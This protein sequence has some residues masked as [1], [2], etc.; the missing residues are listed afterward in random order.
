MQLP[1]E[2]LVETPLKNP[3][4]IEIPIESPL[5]NQ[6]LNRTPIGVPL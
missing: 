6:I 1:I 2:S 4:C 3:N 5:V